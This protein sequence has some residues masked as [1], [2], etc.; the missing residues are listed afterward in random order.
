MG[1]ISEIGGKG[2]RSLDV[3]ICLPG[4]Q[5]LYSLSPPPHNRFIFH[6][7]TI[8]LVADNDNDGQR[9]CRSL[10]ANPG[11]PGPRSSLIS[12]SYSCLFR[13]KSNLK[14][15]KVIPRFFLSYSS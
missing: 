8:L 6:H 14:R 5:G 9:G 7:N 12:L 13:D 2:K 10:T 4:C 3:L 11:Q 15:L 1:D